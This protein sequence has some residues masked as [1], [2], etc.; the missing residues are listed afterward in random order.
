MMLWPKAA[1]GWKGQKGASQQPDILCGVASPF[2][3]T[4]TCAGFA[5]KG[6]LAQG[7]IFI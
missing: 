7:I 4:H 6:L 3:N 5:A 2:V 1:P